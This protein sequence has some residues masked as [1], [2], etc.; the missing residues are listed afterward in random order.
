VSSLI[1]VSGT[2]LLYEHANFAGVV[3]NA[4]TPGYYPWVEDG[5]VNMANDSISSFKVIDWRPDCVAM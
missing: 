5:S 2:W 1:V 3:S 4:L